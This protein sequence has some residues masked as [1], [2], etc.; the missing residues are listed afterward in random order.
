HTVTLLSDGRVLVAGGAD[1]SGPLRSIDIYDPAA[2]TFSDWGLLNVARSGHTASILTDGR[3]LIAGGD[4]TVTTN[5][6][7]TSTA[8]IVDP[9]HPEYVSP[10]YQMTEPR[11]GHS[12][13]P[14]NNSLVYLAGGNTNPSAELFNAT[15]PD[16]LIFST[17]GLAIPAM[18]TA[19]IGHT[20]IIGADNKIYL[21]GGDAAG[22]VELND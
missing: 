14:L 2:R 7:E 19:R 5:G 9:A 17:D 20:A 3:I 13:T 8:E 18:T 16:N 1:D 6:A 22:S 4:R 21:I 12:A 10:T 11:S 15:D